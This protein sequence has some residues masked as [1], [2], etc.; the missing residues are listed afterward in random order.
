[1][2]GVGIFSQRE[3]ERERKEKRERGGRV[4]EE[5]TGAW[6]SSHIFV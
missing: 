4:G 2:T 3:R 1:M 5:R 6:H